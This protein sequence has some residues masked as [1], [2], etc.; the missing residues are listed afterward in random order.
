MI[1]NTPMRIRLPAT[2]LWI[3]DS[4]LC[5][6]DD[7]L[8]FRARRAAAADY[9]ERLLRDPYATGAIRQACLA[10]SIPVSQR[11][12]DDL[13]RQLT[14]LLDLGTVHFCQWDGNAF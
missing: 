1:S 8:S 2:D 13:R 3:C 6:E 7:R 10:R 4:R 11:S 14:I 12:N 9:L 5:N